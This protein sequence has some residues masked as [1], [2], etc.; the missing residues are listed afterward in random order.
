M[1]KTLIESL[2]IIVL[3]ALI[4]FGVNAFHPKG[5]DFIG[6]SEIK[7]G[8]IVLLSSDEIKIKYDAEIA[9]FIDSRQPEEFEYGHIKG[10][11]NIPAVPESLSLKYLE[12][13]SEIIN[14]KNELVIY[15][16]GEACGSSKILGKRIID[17]GYSRHI[18]LIKNGL[19]EWKRKGFPLDK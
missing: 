19:P 7:Y 6:K 3:A 15:C 5:Y 18:Y 12:K 10:A 16:D 4:G 17:L 9:R 11:V 8:K 14:S 1:K 2:I 13:Y